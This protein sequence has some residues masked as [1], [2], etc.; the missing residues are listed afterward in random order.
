[1]ESGFESEVQAIGAEL[2]R[3][4][5][6]GVPA[7]YRGM[8]GWLLKG[9][10][11]D[12]ALR[13]ALFQFVDVLPQLATRRDVATHLA[14]YLDGL[15][16]TRPALLRLAA[17]PSLAAFATLGVR[18]LA[19]QFLVDETPAAIGRVARKL[20]R[21]PA[22]ITI[23]AVGEAVLTESEA[24]A[25]LAR[26]LKLLD[27]LADAG[28]PHLSLKFTALTPHFDGADRDG[29]RRRVFQRIGP[30]IERAI[31]RKA[32][33]TIDMEQYEL[34]PLILDLFLDLLTA[35]P[36][37]AWQPA[38][39]LQAY[40]PGTGA[41]VDRLLAA[42][43]AHARR[44]GVR[45]VKG[46][47]WDQE[48]AW[49]AQRNWPRP[50]FAGKATTDAHFETLT[51]RLLE[52]ADTLHPAIASHNLRSQAVAL[53]WARRLGVPRER[54]EAQL[55]YGMA[56][57]L[58]ATLAAAGVDLRIYVPSGDA[59]IGIAYLIRRLLENTAS[60]SVLRQTYVQ[61][62]NDLAAP[63][64]GE[65][66]IAAAPGF[67]LPLIDFS[68]LDEQAAFDDAL[69]ATRAGL[70]RDH[71]L[72]GRGATSRYVAC[73]P[74]APEETLGTV[75][76]GDESCAR[77]ILAQATAAFPAWRDTGA[78]GRAQALRRA[79]DILASRRRELAALELLSVAKNRREAD[80]DVAEA[81]DYLRYY[82][83]EIERLAGWQTTRDFPGERNAMAYEPYGVA[84]VI[85][86]WNF[87]LAILAGMSSA[88]LA[89]GNCAI[90]KP[91]QPGLLIGFEFRRAL[92]EA[93]VPPDACPLLAAPGA[94]AAHLVGHPDVHVIAFTGSR[95]V[96]LSILQAAH[97]TTAGQRHVKRVVCE[98]GG[99]NA[100][101]VDDDADL[102]D[103]IAGILASAFGYAG[104]KCSACSRV[105]AVAGIHDRLL[106]RLAEAA[107]ALPW[108]PPEDP[109]C[110]FGPVVDAA[111][112]RKALAWL[113]VGRTEGRL[114]W[115]GRVP[116]RGWYVPP[117]LFADIEP[118]HRLA[119]E[120]IFAPIV[121]V[122]KAPDFAGAL[123]MAQD[124]D[125]A[126]TGGVY[127]RLPDHLAL[128]QASYRVGN[129][130][131]NRRITGARVGIQPF[132]GIALSGTGVQAGGP[133]YLKQFLW[134]RVVSANVM[135]H[136]LIARSAS[137]P[138]E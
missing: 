19:R 89:A 54:W 95:D 9:A 61:G 136:G 10:M 84:L 117:T 78:H 42:A 120:E 96:G 125:Y 70:P 47:Y 101:I 52:N 32:T 5:G 23:D 85:A 122:M 116:G 77:R 27:W 119:R 88:A 92:V 91:A 87:P 138:R 71:A 124:A 98:M 67:N 49:A 76:L 106:A 62:A 103:A 75:E 17:R 38:V 128:A 99:K 73:N 105:I 104:Q 69:R 74:A 7:V 72:D 60:T 115:Q 66:P 137:A 132:G 130:Y 68:R 34:K 18:M 123:A 41:D 133:D 4:A 2:R 127:S 134:S 15:D 111:A 6:S 64:A 51:R 13:D 118:H 12:D 107:D 110:P 108:G 100:I 46:A 22:A 109:A 33:L 82:A 63:Q 81:V 112:Q 1:M 48:A 43:Q 65:T 21:I 8:V 20:A 59:A 80:A 86:P 35:W 40:L 30:L 135:R 39:A 44:L 14:A 24:D 57:P 36:N 53:A 79:A 114:Y 29:T 97:A 45:L 113:D 28:T 16:G 102:D 25:Y 58:R 83:D 55:L 31:A 93:G 94:V 126:L 37:P 56:E 50:T 11:D 129:L 3:A 26:N 121:A 90:I 131:L